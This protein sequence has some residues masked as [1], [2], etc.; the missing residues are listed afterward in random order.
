[1]ATD[2]QIEQE[3]RDKGLTAPRVTVDSINA[4]I[5]GSFFFTAAEGLIGA[6]MLS[7]A[8]ADRLPAPLAFL[9]ICVLV[10]ENGFTVL[11]KSGVASAENFD[12]EVGKKVARA[13][14]F[15]Q[16]WPLEGYLLRENL[17]VLDK[18]LTPLPPL[19]DDPEGR[20]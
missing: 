12:A 16:I 13:D 9:T 11:G 7:P 1:M 3:I 8:E 14:A 15:N 10:L 4:K 6:D 20:N 19:V 5:M 17:H 2:E 18:P